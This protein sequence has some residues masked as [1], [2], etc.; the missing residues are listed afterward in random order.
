MLRWPY[1]FRKPEGINKG[2]P[3][4][5]VLW[6]Y[7]DCL[8]ENVFIRAYPLAKCGLSTDTREEKVI[9]SLTSFPARI[10]QAYYAIKSL[11]IQSY[12]PDRIILWLAEEQF[13][14]QSLPKRIHRLQEKGIEVCWCD[15]LRSHKKYHYALQQQKD[16]EVVIT[17]DDD[18]IYEFDSIEKLIE[19]H[20]RY[21][22]CI[23][24]NRAHE[25]TVDHNGKLKPYSEWK[26]H[27]KLGT[28]APSDLL[29]PSTGNGCLY[30]YHI[31]PDVTFDWQIAKTYA[32]TADDIW[33][34]YCSWVG[35]VTVVKTRETIAT[36]CNV[37]GSQRERL[38][39]INDIDGENQQVI[40][41]LQTI[42]GGEITRERN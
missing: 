38:T 23:I 2:I 22:D 37:F 17:Y 4:L 13:P 33:M 28:Q 16:N 18:I 35:N 19:M 11:M 34:K 5:R 15:D 41:R 32:L 20:E 40:D 30:P 39:Q 24:C 12:K 25:I 42:F 14:N 10:D 21:P 1:R 3:K 9:V 8:A 29:M 31:M 36:L 27:S 26:I 7:F 6:Y